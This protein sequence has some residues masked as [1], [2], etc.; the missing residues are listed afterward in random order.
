MGLPLNTDLEFFV[1]FFVLNLA[2]ASLSWFL[3]EKPF[4]GLKKYFRY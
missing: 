2:L 1:L 3:I 4:V